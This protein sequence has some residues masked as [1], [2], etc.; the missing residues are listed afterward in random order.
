MKFKNV[1]IKEFFKLVAIMFVVVFI[2]SMLYLNYLIDHNMFMYGA[3]IQDSMSVFGI[4][5]PKGWWV[6]IISF[7]ITFICTAIGLILGYIVEL[8]FKAV[9]WF[10][11]KFYHIGK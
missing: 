11:R 10:W 5:V 4:M 8:F 2:A 3:I 1:T 9:F 6:I 7:M